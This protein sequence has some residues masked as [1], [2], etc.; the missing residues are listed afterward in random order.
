MNLINRS[1]LG[2]N[3]KNF[4][5]DTLIIISLILIV[6]CL[7]PAVANCQPDTINKSRFSIHAQTTIVTQFKP[8]FSA[9][10]S[11]SN[12]LS[13]KSESQRSIT[14]TLFLGTALWRGASV[15]VN[16][17]IGGGSG[18]SGSS[19]VAASTNGET[20]R[21]GNP[22]PEFELARLF[23][24]QIIPLNS[25]T[26]YFENDI[27]KVAATLP[28]HYLSITVGKIS[29]SDIFDLNRY[30]HDPRTQFLSWGLMNNGAW[31]YPANTRGYT[32]SAVLEY[33][34][35]VH[36]LRY[37]FSLIST[38]PNG[39]KMNWDISRAGSHTLEYT[40]NYHIAGEE[41]TTRI[42]SYL[43]TGNMGNYL[44]SITLSPDAPVIDETRKYG[45]IKYGFGIS[46]DQVL[47]ND[48]GCF[49][50]AG[51]NDGREE[52][53]EFTEIDRTLSFGL[54]L[55]GSTWNR[56]N[57]N[58]GLAYVIS[59]LS[60]SHRKYLKS[61]GYGFELG[62]GNLNYAMENLAELYYSFSLSKEITVSGE[63]QFLNNPGYNK[64]RGPVNIFSVRVHLE[65]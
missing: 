54:S 62:D 16:P 51:W 19:G 29:A 8:N 5:K 59:G 10:Y 46:S 3:R 17:E 48:L 65:I 53:W 32:P 30:S 23:I 11:G 4:R 2:Y 31:D 15:Y 55:K 21:I 13:N 40:Y 43:M 24:R 36:Q 27:N 26:K 35:P 12:S 61:G 45:R 60:P 38:I 42:L 28:T 58:I 20:Y 34:T 6:L 18:L 33:I 52:T 44:Q 41:G 49:L 64:D 56:Q 9:K 63:Y 1:M 57:D 7:K 14:A 47:S 25:E 39:M 22:A 37:G 50:R